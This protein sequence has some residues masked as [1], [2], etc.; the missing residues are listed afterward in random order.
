LLALYGLDSVTQ[1]LISGSW[2]R[3]SWKLS[4][5]TPAIFNQC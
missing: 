2:F 4:V 3:W 1:D 5:C